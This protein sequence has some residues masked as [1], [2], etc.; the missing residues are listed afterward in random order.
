VTVDY[1]RDIFGGERAL[2]VTGPQFDDAHADRLLR[3]AVNRSLGSNKSRAGRS[4]DD[5]KG[6]T[7]TREFGL[8]H[9]SDIGA[10]GVQANIGPMDHGAWRRFGRYEELPIG[11]ITA[12]QPAVHRKRVEELTADPSLGRNPRLPDEKPYAMRYDDEG[13][14]RTTMLLNGHHRVVAHA[15]RNEMFAPA[16]VIDYDDEAHDKIGQYNDAL[17]EMRQA[18][19]GRRLIREGVVV[20]GA[21]KRTEEWAEGA[22]ERY[23]GIRR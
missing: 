15:Q 8:P 7:Q 4:R 17:N 20:G 21:R 23:H 9:A 13:S 19:E 6:Y 5:I 18:A 22:R 11:E 12:G 1:Q 2:T 3:R 14:G 10:R 16:R